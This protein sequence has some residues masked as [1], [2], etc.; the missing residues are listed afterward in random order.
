MPT[1][2][3]DSMVSC[4]YSRVWV[5]G[6]IPAAVSDFMVSCL[7]QSLT[8]WCHAYSGVWLKVSCL[9]RS[10]TQ[11]CHAY[12]RVWV[13]GV[14]PAV[15]SDSMVSCL[16]GVWLNGVMPTAESDSMVACP[17]RVWKH[18]AMTTKKA[19][20]LGSSLPCSF[21]YLTSWCLTPR[22]HA[23]LEVWLRGYMPT[24]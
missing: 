15:E 18:L 20:S 1:V 6:V 4:L 23:H 7:Q 11:W 10:M 13:N 2:E 5:N 17:H 9:Q 21:V 3:Y 8:P 14:I 12:S 22:Y 24:A 16:H 19:D